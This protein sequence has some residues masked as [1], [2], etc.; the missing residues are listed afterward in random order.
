MQRFNRFL[1]AVQK[2]GVKVLGFG[3]GVQSGGASQPFV[4]VRLRSEPESLTLVKTPLHELA[5]QLGAHVTRFPVDVQTAASQYGE[6]VHIE[7]HYI[8]VA[9][10]NS[11]ALLQLVQRLNYH[12]KLTLI[13]ASEI[14]KA[15]EKMQP[16]AAEE[17][18]SLVERITTRTRGENAYRV[19]PEYEPTPAMKNE[20]AL[21]ARDFEFE[22][23]SEESTTRL[24]HYLIR[25]SWIPRPR[26]PVTI[27]LLDRLKS[28][29]SR[30][31]PLSSKEKDALVHA[32]R[33]LEQIRL[34]TVETS[35]PKRDQTL[36]SAIPAL[37]KIE[38]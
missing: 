14:K 28:R 1:E 21:I 35:N 6:P 20:P 33:A 13:P 9:R 26:F 5:N 12:H 11:D 37:R 2:T 25:E 23:A 27:I 18:P 17:V 36:V 10:E 7:T 30:R 22:V 16:P 32:R 29:L 38:K 4:A 8:P 31:A 19:P 34:K 15:A 3:F 24:T